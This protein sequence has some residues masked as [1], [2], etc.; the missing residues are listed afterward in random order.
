[1]K[2]LYILCFYILLVTLIPLSF[3]E[4]KVIVEDNGDYLRLE[5]K[6]IDYTSSKHTKKHK[7]HRKKE[8]FYIS[9]KGSKVFHRP[10][11]RF[12]KRIKHKVIYKSRREALKHHLRPCK[13][14]KP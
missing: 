7:H 3:A 6:N 11:C 14:C 10:D 13:V 8:N 9:K 4:E 12:A 1:M 2:I 5:V